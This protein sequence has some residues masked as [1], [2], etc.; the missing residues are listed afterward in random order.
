MIEFKPKLPLPF[1]LLNKVGDS[2][3]RLNLPSVELSEEAVRNP[4]IKRTGLEDF[5]EQYHQEG[6]SRVLESA[7]EDA[8]LHFIGRLIIQNAVK[9]NLM[10]RLW[11]TEAVKHHTE[12]FQRPLR[13]PI[14]VIGLPRTGTTFLHRMLAADPAN[15]AVPMWE[16]MRPLPNSRT[17]CSWKGS[18]TYRR[19]MAKSE[20]GLWPK[21]ARDA[22]RK[23]YFRPDL[24][25]ECMWLLNATFVSFGFWV[26]APVYRYLEWYKKHDRFK[27]YME[28]RQMLQVLQ[29][30]D[31]NRRL[32]LKAPA[33]TGSID[34]LLHAIPDALIIQI[35]R[36]PVTACNSFSSLL[37]TIHS[38][39][40]NKIDIKAMAFAN[41]SFLANEIQ[42]NIAARATLPN[43]IVDVHYDKLATEPIAT[44]GDIYEH[45]GL[46]WSETFQDNLNSY[47]TSN[48]K[49]KHGDHNYDSATFGLTD[50][51]ISRQFEQ[52]YK[53]FNITP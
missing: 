20:I 27:S 26:L 13:P 49:G 41:L 8:N 18:A 38:A 23:R 16:L 46:R 34:A 5:G 39:V 7:V 2:L 6:L 19:Y 9:I 21:L 29:A 10:K 12:I 53:R 3:H 28:Y 44:V 14:I 43:T 17:T 51:E 48:P 45:F 32:T 40:S 47:V 50:A 52:Y 33:H 15:R 11:L 1:R 24:P 37:Y 35:H 31:P 36:D 22:D 42:R 4:A 25:D 30:V